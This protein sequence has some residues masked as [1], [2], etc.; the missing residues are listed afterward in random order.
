MSVVHIEYPETMDEARMRPRERGLNDPRL[1]SIDRAFKCGTCDEDMNECPGHFGHIELAAPVFHVGEF[2]PKSS[3]YDRA[4][5][6]VGFI[7]KIK[8][9][10]EI[11]CHNCG[12]LLQDEVSHTKG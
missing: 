7:N 6:F 10:L 8:K 9:I 4:D 2:M 3:R 1:G 11:V 5:P 12:K